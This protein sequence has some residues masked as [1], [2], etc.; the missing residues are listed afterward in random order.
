MDRQQELM[1]TQALRRVGGH[2][3]HRGA[4]HQAITREGQGPLWPKALFGCRV[5]G[6]D[7]A[8][9]LCSSFP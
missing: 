4:V 8:G 1:E 6:R 7:L 9:H 5:G 2:D 3:E